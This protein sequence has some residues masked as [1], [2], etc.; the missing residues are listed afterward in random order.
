MLTPSKQGLFRQFFRVQIAAVPK[1]HVRHQNELPLA[2]FLVKGIAQVGPEL[3]FPGQ[4]I[5]SDVWI[6]C[7]HNPAVKPEY[8]A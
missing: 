3:P 6:S 7:N 8:G 2:E 5:A 1:L 4:I